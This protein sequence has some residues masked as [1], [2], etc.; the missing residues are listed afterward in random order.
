MIISLDSI[1]A[2]LLQYKYILL[3]PI[4]V[5]EGPIVTVIAGFL[6]SMG[7][8]NLLLAYFLV[9]IADVC[10]DVMFYYFGRIGRLEW[11]RRWGKYFG[12]T[13]DRVKKVEVLYK[14][15]PGKTILFGKF[16]HVVSAPVLI[17]AG[18]SKMPLSLFIWWNFLGTL[19]KSLAFLMLGFY[20]GQAY[21]TINRYLNDFFI[22][23]SILVIILAI[24]FVLFGKIFDKYAPKE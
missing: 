16:S 23:G 6:V 3:F 10:G 8:M 18:I 15:H 17:A 12:L 22:A 2:L 9:V 20:F 4:V 1:F 21:T 14:K 13:E 19:P 24:I 7:A 5:V 11:V